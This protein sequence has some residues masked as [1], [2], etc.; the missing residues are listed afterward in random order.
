MWLLNPRFP[1]QYSVLICM[2]NSHL[3]SRDCQVAAWPNILSFKIFINSPL[4]KSYCVEI[5]W[6]FPA[7]EVPSNMAE[8]VPRAISPPIN[9]H[10][11]YQIKAL[12]ASTRTRPVNKHHK[13]RN[14]WESW[15]IDTLISTPS[16][17]AIRSKLNNKVSIM[18]RRRQK[19]QHPTDVLLAAWSW[20][21]Q[22]CSHINFLNDRSCTNTQPKT[23]G[24]EPSQRWT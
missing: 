24:P 2:A 22:H 3:M 12:L 17:R 23:I 18:A 19:S 5:Y 6:V 7:L 21:L 13:S 1:R 14:K 10:R 9:W 20:S 8:E 11:D 16:L 4:R 15:S